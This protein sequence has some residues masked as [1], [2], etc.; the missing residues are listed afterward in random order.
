MNILHE[1]YQSVEPIDKTI[2]SYSGSVVNGF[3][4]LFFNKLVDIYFDSSK[5]N[6]V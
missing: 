6:V 3:C 2:I 1:F 4:K 5:S